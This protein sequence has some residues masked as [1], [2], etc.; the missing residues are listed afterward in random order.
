MPRNWQRLLRWTHRKR[1]NAVLIGLLIFVAGVVAW[2]SPGD[3]QAG[4]APR[5]IVAVVAAIVVGAAA[6]WLWRPRH[7]GLQVSRTLIPEG[8]VDSD[9]D[10]VDTDRDYLVPRELP[11]GPAAFVG[12][13]DELKK[14]AYELETFDGDRPFVA[15][16]QGR[17]GIGKTALALHFAHQIADR[18]P[19]GQTFVHVAEWDSESATYDAGGP[20][21]G[22]V[23][24]VKIARELF[25]ALR[26]PGEKP[27]PGQL[28]DEYR[29]LSTGRKLLIVLDDVPQHA[30]LPPLAQIGARG[31]I[32]LTTRQDPTSVMADVS[33]TEPGVPVLDL[34]ELEEEAALNLLRRAVGKQE[35]TEPDMPFRQLAISCNREPLA[36]TLAGAALASRSN[37][38][39]QDLISLGSTATSTGYK[40]VDEPLDA[41]YQLLTKEEQRALR[42]VGIIG[43]ARFAAW[44]LQATLDDDDGDLTRALTSGLIRSGLIART[45]SGAGGVTVFEVTE[46]VVAYARGLAH[47]PDV[48]QPYPDLRDALGRL[49]R[50]SAERRR[51]KP[52][53]RIRKEVYPRMRAGDFGAAIRRARD[54][55][56][57]AQD[58]RDRSAQAV[59]LAALA[60]LY[61]ELGEISAAEDAAQSA[62]RI[63]EDDSADSKARA[64]RSLAKLRRRAH[65]FGEAE[66]L[67]DK[68]L[69]L[70]R[71]ADDPGEE[72]RVLAER[73]LIR[74]RRG[75]FA[76]A[77]DDATVA[78]S[79]SQPNE[80]RQLPVA[81]LAH[82][83]SLLYEARFAVADDEFRRARLARAQ[84]VFA[85]AYRKAEDPQGDGSKQFLNMS[86]I[87][88]AQATAALDQGDLNKATDWAS[89][90]MAFFTDMHHRYGVAHCRR[91]VGTISMRLS[92]PKSAVNELLGALETFRN[93]G[94]TR[95]VADV[96]LE[97]AQALLGVGK[98]A[99]AH[100]LQRQAVRIYLQLRDKET[101]SAAAIAFLSSLASQFRRNPTIPPLDGPAE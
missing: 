88:Y 63:G 83:R 69:D 81:M 34:Q 15:V 13:A 43:Q 78:E 51:E 33:L 99:E 91:L 75:D 66:K 10:G 73:A 86:W 2:A 54:T 84:E 82:G 101:A 100:S 26:Q 92:Q 3:V 87:R 40:R 65:H 6:W 37:W 47:R 64:L 38:Q 22:A 18:F 36:L 93:C 8:T 70:S 48:P 23:T 7:G 1:F 96:S 58:N 89:D 52:S 11:P 28:I 53:M 20:V 79:L 56:A 44:A 16:I 14:L 39:L 71:E 61:A 77:K 25:L 41:T 24:E 57:Q 49:K 76:R 21:T 45:S 90:A 94:D 29:R 17:A 59:C 85:E 55:L 97:L 46:P 5:I 50:Q 74:G 95:I 27:P 67:L 60:E 32:I 35:L 30:T 42:C 19:D 98:H 80:L 4:R 62:R 31:A 12:R 72:I 68:A 9:R